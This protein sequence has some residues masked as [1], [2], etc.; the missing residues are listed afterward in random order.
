MVV[1]VIGSDGQLGSALRLTI[2]PSAVN[3][4][5]SPPTVRWLNRCDLDLADGARIASHPA[6]AGPATGG[7]CAVVVNAAAY[8]AVDAAEEHRDLA[9]AVNATAPGLLAQRCEKEHCRFLHLS[10]DYVFGSRAPHRPLRPGD[11]PMPDN[12]YGRTKL[13]GERAARAAC[14]ETTILRTAWVY[15]GNLLP[16]HQDFVGTMMRMALD[17]AHPTVVADQHGCP[18]YVAD[19]ARAVWREVLEPC[20]APGIRH[21]VGA[22]VATWYE[23]ARAVFQAMG[24][25]PADVHPTDTAGY[26]TPARRPPWSVLNSDHRLPGWRSGVGRAVAGTLGAL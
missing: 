21:A 11:T 7:S 2:P 24:R 26:P 23:V 15:S 6:L 17:G 1:T 22:G 18:T 12:V 13:M 10:T 14:A 19:L 9:A 4:D 16:D 8:T 20:G 25:D 3:A 5:G